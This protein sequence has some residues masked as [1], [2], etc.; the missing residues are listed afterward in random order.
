MINWR[1]KFIR[2]LGKSGKGEYFRRSLIL[3]LLITSVP[4]ALIAVSNYL[5]GTSQIEKQVNKLHK[6]KIE[7]FSQAMNEQISQM[8]LVLSRW[9]TNPM[10]GDRLDR[11][12]FIEQI[13]QTHDLM[14]NM[15]VVGGSNLLIGDAQLYLSRQNAM[16]G[17]D[18][19]HYL[20]DAQTASFQAILRDHAGLLWAYGLPDFASKTS[21]SP[22]SLIFKLPWASDSPFGAFV[23][24]L[25][26]TEMLTMLEHYVADGQGAAL[27]IRPD[28]EWVVK[29]E[30][31]NLAFQEQLRSEIK[32]HQ[33]ESGEFSFHWQKE[34]FVVTYGKVSKTGWLYAIA[35]PVTELTGPVVLTSKLILITSMI[36]ILVSI[37]LGWFA[38]NQL[39]R[40]IGKLV[41]LFRSGRE[42]S[43][44]PIPREIQFIE[45]E[46]MKL[47][48]ESVSMRD[49][50]RQSLP[51][52][53]E[54]FFLQLVQGHLYALREQEL[55][56]RMGELG[57]DA[58]NRKISLLYVQLSGLSESKRF[59]EHDQ[60]LVTFAAANIVGEI[61]AARADSTH[62]INF[63]DLS[64]GV[65]L[66]Y[67]EDAVL[68]GI[69][70]ELF[71]WSQEMAITISNVLGL[72]VTVVLGR[73]THQI[74]HIPEM[75]E[76]ARQAARFRDMQENC[77][78]IDMEEVTLSSRPAAP[79]PFAVEKELLQVM[80]LGMEEEAYRLLD[81]FV[82]E[83]E[84]AAEWEL[85][86]CQSLM[87]LVYGMRHMFI[88]TGF[89]Q[90]PLLIDSHLIEE[91][92]AV[93]EAVL[94]KKVVKT[95]IM[96][97]YLEQFQVLQNGRMRHIIEQVI[98][99][100]EE[101][102]REDLSLDECARA[103][104]S[105]PYTLS[106]SFKQVTG[107]TFVDYLTRLRIR[108][109]KELLLTTGLK[110]NEIAEHVGYQH[111][112][113]NKI[114]KG[115]EGMTPTQFRDQYKS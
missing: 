102:Y 63:Q 42:D 105:N 60:Q 90:H 82:E 78:V 76:Q 67:P 52:L 100:M 114:F 111:S 84:A 75:L 27:L 97:P 3:V 10:F 109:A 43:A 108:K 36:G 70:N 81:R 4:S 94:L 44:G 14:Q 51:F 46:W 28:G 26:R 73:L 91:L 45:D 68:E 71:V 9:S 50:I 112:Y 34:S 86:V 96:A 38:S 5:I 48:S 87:Q 83:V 62:I 58:T 74:G 20:N 106:R 61:S 107:F 1:T 54:G 18:G 79:F 16:I 88:E 25:S 95:R 32:R 29:P 77:Q 98:R 17:S 89:Q 85:T 103:V 80:R 65:L 115:S 37:A 6:V 56:T 57:L 40:P 47:S 21:V 55:Q 110:V 59:R 19:I 92:F 11:I 64:V 7:Q 41:A 99:L 49:R 24:H 13:S 33:G 72:Q 2:R 104:A 30:E 53:R 8:E 39:Y 66:L 12:E 31:H 101:R 69:R 35:S 22:V 93:K 23:V 15:L 113:F